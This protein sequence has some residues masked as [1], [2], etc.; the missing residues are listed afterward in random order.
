MNTMNSEKMSF[1]AFESLRKNLPE[2][3]KISLKA[4]LHTLAYYESVKVISDEIR[5]EALRLFKPVVADSECGQVLGTVGEPITSW[6]DLFLANDV[7][8]KA[9]YD[10]HNG[11]MAEKGYR[12]DG[13]RCHVRVTENLLMRA[14]RLLIEAAEPF[15]Q[16]SYETLS[17][18]SIAKFDKYTE[19]LVALLVSCANEQAIDLNI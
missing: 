18:L 4:Y 12:E 5:G 13:G 7:V 11:K 17:R 15:T 9:I 8:S 1:A 14:N 2:G 6:R 3:L 19:L 16:M 10:Y